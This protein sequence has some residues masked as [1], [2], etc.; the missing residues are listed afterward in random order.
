[1]QS[2]AARGHHRT[3]SARRLTLATIKQ[4]SIWHQRDRAALASALGSA[5]NLR[6]EV[7]AFRGPQAQA[8]LLEGVEQLIERCEQVDEA[9]RYVDTQYRTAHEGIR[10]IRRELATLRRTVRAAVRS[11]ERSPAWPGSRAR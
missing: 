1:M 5:R 8:E 6:N 4:R 9:M 10:Q 11:S 7:S 3:G 2:P